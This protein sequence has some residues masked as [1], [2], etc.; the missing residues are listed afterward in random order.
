MKPLREYGLK[1]LLGLHPVRIEI[2]D[3]KMAPRFVD[4]CGVDAFLAEQLEQKPLE[5]YLVQVFVDADYDVSEIHG[6]QAITT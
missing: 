3:Q 2:D 4:A 1:D 5:V 6:L